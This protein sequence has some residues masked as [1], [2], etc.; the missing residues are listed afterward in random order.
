MAVEKKRVGFTLVELLVV[1]AI[2]AI[3]ASLLLPALGQAKERA[4]RMGC[5][6]NLRQIG[7]AMRLYADDNDE[8]FP[9][10]MGTGEIWYGSWHS[11]IR[12][13]L[14][15]ARTN[16]TT[17]N[18]RETEIFR[19]PGSPVETSNEYN[20]PGAS[21][22]VNAGSYWGDG[23]DGG[24]GVIWRRG[25]A[26][27]RQFRN[28]ATFVL[29]TD[30]WP[31]YNN[32][33]YGNDGWSHFVRASFQTRTTGYHNGVGGSPYLFIGGNV[34]FITRPVVYSFGQD[35][36]DVKYAGYR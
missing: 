5:T 18:T 30:F 21:Y 31:A 11:R 34:E 1:I 23:P 19:C 25:S 22:G 33:A 27:L 9:P 24:N 35:G 10:T 4:R 26:S 7:L 14:G 3:L 32:T 2:I 16:A 28:P 36:T 6:N 8:W 29:A 15:I 13:Y 12:K 17:G 20:Y